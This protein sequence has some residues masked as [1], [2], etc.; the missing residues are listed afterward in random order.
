MTAPSLLL[1]PFDPSSFAFS[2]LSFSF[3]FSS[4]AFGSSGSGVGGAFPSGSNSCAKILTLLNV[5]VKFNGG[6]PLGV[7]EGAPLH[8][9]I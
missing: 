9:K 1:T 2:D 4:S 6:G 8:N 3:S 7:G 5:A